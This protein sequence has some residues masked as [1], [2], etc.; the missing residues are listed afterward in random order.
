LL[1]RHSFFG[2]EDLGLAGRLLSELPGIM[3]W[4]LVGYRRLQQRGHFVQPASAN[5]AVEELEALGS[6]VKAYVGN[7][8]A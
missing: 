8:V 4:S 2:R 3:N 6:P 7:A 5:Q 1:L